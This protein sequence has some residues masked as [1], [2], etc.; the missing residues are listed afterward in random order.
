MTAPALPEVPVVIVGAGPTGLT[1]A[2]LLAQQGIECLV[3]ERWDQLYPRPRAVHVDDEVARILAGIGL[4]DEFAAI[5][6]P[7]LGLRLLDPEMRMLAEFRRSA[8]AGRHGFP[9][10]NLFDQPELE[11]VL[12]ANL[13]GYPA[14]KLQG[15]AEV[16][17]IAGSEGKVFIEYT[18]RNTGRRNR[19]AA[20]Y[21]LGCDGAESLVRRSIGSEMRDLR[22]EQRW[23]VVD[24]E[25]SGELGEWEGVHQVCDPERAATYMRIG[26][27]RH[28]WEFRLPPGAG[29]ADFQ[30]IGDIHPLVKPWTKDTPVESL[31]LVR[32]A[33]YTFRAQLAERWRRDRVFILG[34]AAH[35][36]PPF[37]GQ[38]IGAGIRD[39]ENLAWKLAGVLDGSLP[40]R[41]LDTYQ[42]ERMPH[43]RTMIRLAKL[44]GAL[45]TGGG[46]TGGWVRRTVAP[47]LRYVPGLRE[48]VLSSETPPLRL[49]GR[50]LIG[51][52]SPNADLG[53]GR[54]LDQVTGNRFAFITANPPSEVERSEIERRGA[55]LVQADAGSELG[56]WL[57]KGRTQAA[58]IRPDGTVM[59]T[60]RDLRE[61][62]EPL[63][64]ATE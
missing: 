57:R 49:G 42:S 37:I 12:R 30:G 6:R 26:R 32:V 5:S 3:L 48:R 31:S 28:R 39:A 43:A 25:V 60:G 15:N 46:R 53:D 10:A 54:R 55:V 36:T 50:G 22:F 9:E 24:V 17:E 47:R 2:T 58:L 14:A 29:A 33:E 11:A 63:P 16:I 44:V 38:G 45:M 62:A 23:L 40:E 13:A 7:C 4:A 61:L 56:M 19:L 52:L 1:A 64:T 51:R 8:A 35:L 18:D 27:T 59:A 20:E 34:D 21:V 41:V